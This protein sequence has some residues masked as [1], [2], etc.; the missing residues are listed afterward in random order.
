MFD[1]FKNF[2][3]DEEFRINIFDNKVNIVNYLDLIVL[4]DSRISIKS[5]RGIVVVKGNSLTVNRLLDSEILISG[6]IK[7]IELE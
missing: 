1:R 3:K 2:I 6:N 4:E 7:S 5:P